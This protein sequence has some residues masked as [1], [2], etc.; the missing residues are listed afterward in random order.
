[1]PFGGILSL[2]AAGLSAGS[3]IAGLFGGSP[4]SQVQMPQGYQMSNMGGADQ[5][6]Y[7]GIG[8]LG[9]Y[10]ISPGLLPLYQ[11]ATQSMINNPYTSNYFTGANQAGQQGMQSGQQ[12]TGNALSQ[13]GNV[14][15]LMSMGFDPQGALYSQLQNTNQQQNAAILGQSGVA[16]TPY[17]AGVAADA[18]SKFNMNWENQQLGR[19]S[20]AAGA[21][22]GLMNQIGQ[23]TN[24]GL[25]Q[26]QQGAQLPY[27]TFQG[28]NG[29][30]LSALGGLAQFGQQ[31]AQLPQQQIQD[32]LA[33]LSQGSAQ[34]GANNQTAGLGLQQA[35][36][37]FQQ[38]QAMGQQLGGA[39]AGL[40]KGW[41]NMNFGGGNNSLP[42]NW[43]QPGM[44]GIGSA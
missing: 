18:N 15:S 36:Q 17:G 25:N 44:G 22:G 41:G 38:N 19:A 5:G 42:S 39:L 43:T 40:S 11:Q 4:A 27:N 14:N 26:M 30:N 21:A 32:Y 10:N 13:L 37:G 7:G 20:Q 9:Q 2:G 1:M 24:T 28:I 6:A 31:G 16:S 29:N 12:I 8:G 3:S 35:N 33:Y 23:S 34:Q